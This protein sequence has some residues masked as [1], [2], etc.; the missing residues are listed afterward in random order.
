[1]DW[2][3]LYHETPTDPKWRVI[4]KKTGQRI[5][6]VLAVWIFILTNASSNATE[7]GRTHNLAPEDIAAALDLETSDVDA[8]IAAMEG[9]TIAQGRLLGWEKRNPI[10]EDGSAERAKRWRQANAT[11]RLRTLA[12]ATERKRT[13]PNESERPESEGD[14]DTE[15]ESEKEKSRSE[16]R[17][18]DAAEF[19]ELAK[20][21]GFDGNDHRNWLEFVAMKTRH[22]LEFEAHILAAAR[23]HAAVGKVGKTLA[24][25]RPKAIELRDAARIAATAPVVFEDCSPSEWAGRLRFWCEYSGEKWEAQWGPRWKP[26]WG[27]L[28]SSPDN[29]VPPD[30]LTE[31]LPRLRAAAEADAAHDAERMAPKDRAGA[32]AR[33][34]GAVA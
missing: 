33:P 17:A 3:R 8:I 31:W 22:G 4:A 27:P 20:I 10:K 5:G 2:V 21:L 19:A 28:W 11:E 13:L 23:H 15:T 34:Q 6:D 25:I 24:Y 26:K 9:K 16:A 12:N 14:T 7:R 32:V 30:V 29:R 1:M 18:R